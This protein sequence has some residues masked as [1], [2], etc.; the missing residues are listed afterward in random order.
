MAI[1]SVLV[2]AFRATATIRE[3]IESILECQVAAG[4]HVQVVVAPDDESIEY[5]S[6]L[7][8]YESV[9]V[10]EPTWRLG[11]GPGRNRARAAA[12]G[13]WLTLIDADDAV[14]PGY[15]DELLRVANSTGASCV[16]SRTRYEQEGHL[17]RELPPGATLDASSMAAFA[18]SIH[19]LYQ[20]DLWIDYPDDLAEDAFVEASLLSAVGGSAPLASAAI[21]S[22]RLGPQGLCA[23]TPQERFNDAYRHVLAG[24]PN[25]VVIDVFA[26][27]LAMGILYAKHGERGG[28]LSFHQFVASAAAL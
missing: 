28:T 19:A 17:V 15:L 8:G 22:C 20:R 3:A 5:A 14:S 9:L 12:S 1:V 23:T 13:E 7:R 18:G 26:A 16:F 21:Y 6:M 10:L 4:G 27:R 11:P 24:A 2:P 25:A